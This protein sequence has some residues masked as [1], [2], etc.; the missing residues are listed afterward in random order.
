MTQLKNFTADDMFAFQGA[1]H[2]AD[3][4]VPRI[5][6]FSDEEMEDFSP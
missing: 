4:S 2:F 1:E 5:Y 3:G 6:Y